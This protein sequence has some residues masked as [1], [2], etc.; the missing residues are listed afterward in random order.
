MKRI[1]IIAGEASGDL[2]ATRLLRALKAERPDWQFEGIAG[3]EMQAAGCT[4]LFPL[5]KLAVMG[6]VEVLRHLPELLTIRRR[7]LRRWQDN[8]PDLFIGVDAPDFNLPLAAKLHAMGVPTV[9]YVSPS[10]WAWRQ[11]RVRKLRGNVDLMLTLFPFEASFYHAHGIP[12]VFVGHPLADEMVFDGDRQAAR[13]AL[14]LPTAGRILAV[15]PGSRQGEVQRLAPAF[16]LAAQ[17]LHGRHPDLQ[18]VTPAASPALGQQ[19]ESIRQ[20][21]APDL[22]L[23]VVSRQSRTVMQA[24]DALL[25]AS[26]TA[27][28]E[29]MLAG[30]LMVAAYKVAPLTAWLLRTF[31]LLKV[32]YVTLPNNLAGEGLVPE[33]LQEEVT[34]DKLVTEVEAML[35]IPAER[36]QY[37]LQRFHELYAGLRRDASR[38]AAHAILNHFV[39]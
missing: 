26:G 38:S 27:A 37:V 17:A 28:L 14:G 32:Q 10:V 29:G 31:R 7:L 19:L 20:Q 34:P 18:F 8:P 5:E 36:R 13:Q 3:V 25:L 33:V 2:L 15:L 22:P 35:A 11:G 24:A 30:R 4:S 9:H 12:A 16:L 39:M 21:V 6:L 23:T 1:A